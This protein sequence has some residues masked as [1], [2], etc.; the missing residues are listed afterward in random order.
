MITRFAPSPTGENI[1]IG[2]LRIAVLNH[3]HA[4][5]SG[6]KFI[7]RIEDT[8]NDRLVPECVNKILQCMTDM[9]M[10][11][12]EILYQS[13]NKKC[14]LMAA[15][16]LVKKGEAYVKDG[17][18]W[19]PGNS[20]S[21]VDGVYGEKKGRFDDFVIIRSNGEPSFIFANIVDDI[22]LMSK[23]GELTVI[24]GN[25]HFDNTLKQVHICKLLH[26]RVPSYYSVS[27]VHGLDG[28]PLSK[29]DKAGTVESLL[30]MGIHPEALYKYLLAL[31]NGEDLRKMLKSPV[32]VD[33]KKIK[34]I[35]KEY[36]TRDFVLSKA[37]YVEKYYDY[38]KEHIRC[39]EDLDMC[40]Y[41]WKR[42]D[43]YKPFKG[44]A[45]GCDFSTF[46]RESAQRIIDN[47]VR[48]YAGKFVGADGS[49]MDKKYIYSE[50]RKCLCGTP[51]SLD[52]AIVMEALGVEECIA[53]GLTLYN[54]EN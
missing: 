29:R 6:G 13:E 32:T 1:H 5:K 7:L 14:H 23:Y 31:G 27:M 16:Y 39:I 49:L 9:N 20:S 30:D 24:R 41:L 19:I 10:T 52:L 47:Y 21:F 3:Y 8:L 46:N 17:A 33:I 18:I 15:D 11:P 36:M 34:S 28:K 37:P 50:L 40:S 22:Y 12:D 35:N 4:V 43:A 2:N 51:Y 54:K 25:D 53:R 48:Y 38:V 42:P 26:E 45:V 44:F